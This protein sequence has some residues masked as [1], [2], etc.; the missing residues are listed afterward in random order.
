MREME[1]KSVVDDL[2]LRRQRVEAMGGQLLF[3]GLMEDRYYDP[4]AS[5]FGPGEK[6]RIRT[7]Q[8]LGTTRTELT[9]K[10]H[11]TRERGYKV[12]EELSTFVE[13]GQ[14]LT[15][16]LAR[17]R[18]VPAQVIERE[19]W[20]YS[21]AGAIVR[22]EQYPVMDVLVEVE[23]EPEAIEQAIQATGLPREGFTPES[24]ADF[25]QRFEQRTGSTAQLCP[26]SDRGRLLP[27]WSL[28]AR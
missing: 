21:C 14:I 9:W 8:G 1:L 11:A 20:I 23:G 5:A 2:L 26:S 7:F 25:F 15:E 6:L 17:L 18:F 22:F 27:S 13:D 3:S 28:S 4:G 10:G 12:R 24:K 19:V 16:I